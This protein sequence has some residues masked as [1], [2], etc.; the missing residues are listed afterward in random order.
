MG[1]DQFN[2]VGVRRGIST[3]EYALLLACIVG[4]LLATQAMLRRAISYK[5]RQ[6]ADSFGDGRQYEPRGPKATIIVNYID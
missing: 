1:Y 2:S 6:S 5:W 3:L 4:A